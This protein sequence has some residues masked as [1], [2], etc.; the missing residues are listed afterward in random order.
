MERSVTTDGTSES[1][2]RAPRPVRWALGTL[3]VG[4]AAGSIYLLTVRGPAVLI[5]LYGATKLLLCL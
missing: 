4:L 3:V 2:G 1:D 5:D